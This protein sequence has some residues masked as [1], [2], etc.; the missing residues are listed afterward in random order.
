M[1]DAR[2][3]D[4][5][6]SAPALRAQLHFAADTGAVPVARVA[7]PGTGPDEHSGEISVYEIEI[8]DA[9][10]IAATLDLDRQGFVLTRHT[11]AVGDF[12]ADEQVRRIY[13]LEMERLVAEMT[14]A[15]KVVVFDHT[16]RVADEKKRIER[17]V[18]DPVKRVHNDF[19]ERSAPQRVRD[20]LPPDEA[21]ARLAKRYASI[22]VWRPI[23]G[24]VEIKPLV[25]CGYESIDD[26]DL[27][28][29]E[30]HY[31]DGR[32]GGIYMLVFNPRQRW[33]YFPE[34]TGD[35]VVLL[36]CFDSLTDGTARWTAHGSFD[37]PA[38]RAGAVPRESIEVR[39]LLFFD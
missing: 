6:A 25:V 22:N 2:R 34:M 28:P 17:K 8:R 26:R 11:T 21:E 37:P 9:R 3:D 18:R 14:G 19:T 4:R 30:R 1:S 38:V 7:E 12:Y 16:I 35:E 13:Y 23:V 15:N 33:F 29:A 27:V 24:P 5:I 31:P 32:I 36:K 10:P 20:L 39:T